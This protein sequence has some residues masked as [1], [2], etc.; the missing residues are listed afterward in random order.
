MARVE[1]WGALQ[2]LAGWRVR[3][4]PAA[5]VGELTR[6]IAEADGR[7]GARLGGQ[8]VMVV[9]G[10]GQVRGDAALAADAEVSF[11]PPVTGG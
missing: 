3:D 5:T 4:I 1:L 10:D 9:V 7:L 2:D 8:D 6:A 11:M